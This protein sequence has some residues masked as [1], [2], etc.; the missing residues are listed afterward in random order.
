MRVSNEY[1]IIANDIY[2]D[3]N[4]F[5]FLPFIKTVRSVL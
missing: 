2:W 3:S 4:S 1:N 5:D